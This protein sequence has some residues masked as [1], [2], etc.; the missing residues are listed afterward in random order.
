MCPKIWSKK[1]GTTCLIIIFYIML[2][3]PEVRQQQPSGLKA[4]IFC[5]QSWQ[6][7][8]F[9]SFKAIHIMLYVRL[10]I[11]SQLFNPSSFLKAWYP[12]LQW[13]NTITLSN[14]GI[15]DK[16]QTVHPSFY[17]KIRLDQW[18]GN[19][20]SSNSHSEFNI[21]QLPYYYKWIFMSGIHN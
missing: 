8:I 21:I 15:L 10:S 20:S 5:S 16:R 1:T 12:T 9:N 3:I 17:Q 11:S 7:R 6:P 19:R 4:L 14:T 2:G 13:I 18:S